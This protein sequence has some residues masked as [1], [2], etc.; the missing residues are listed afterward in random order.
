[1][2]R[3]LSNWGILLFSVST[4]ATTHVHL[5]TGAVLFLKS[6]EWLKNETFIELQLHFSVVMCSLD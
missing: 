3:L 2:P 6:G 5:H 4:A 1:M